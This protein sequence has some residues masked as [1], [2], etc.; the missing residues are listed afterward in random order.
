MLTIIPGFLGLVV[1]PAY[2]QA[3]MLQQFSSPQQDFTVLLPNN[4]EIRTRSSDKNIVTRSFTSESGAC[5]YRIDAFTYPP[6]LF[7]AGSFIGFPSTFLDLTQATEAKLSTIR[8]GTDHNILVQGYPGRQ[9]I[10]EKSNVVIT[11]RSLLFGA[12][13]RISYAT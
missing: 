5:V 11:V 7:G 13:W 2:S 9:F 6:N 3:V 10:E 8:E 1:S 4:P 12:P